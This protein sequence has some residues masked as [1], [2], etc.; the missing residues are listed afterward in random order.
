[1]NNNNK[2]PIEKV[3]IARNYTV[4]EQLPPI[5]FI[6]NK[7]IKVETLI[8]TL[9]ELELKIYGVKGNRFE[10]IEN[11]LKRDFLLEAL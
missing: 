1:M 11:P 10:E 2:S 8:E 7:E 9:T 6:D 5:D 4:Y 3:R